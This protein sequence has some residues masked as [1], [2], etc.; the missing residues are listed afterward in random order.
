MLI[1]LVLVANQVSGVANNGLWLQIAEL[2]SSVDLADFL[3]DGFGL[4]QTVDCFD[5]RGG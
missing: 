3:D 5:D 1:L 4:L 2:E